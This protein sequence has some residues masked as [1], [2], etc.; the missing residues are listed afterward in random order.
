M[1]SSDIPPPGV[2]DYV[3]PVSSH[4]L[5]VSGTLWTVSYLLYARESLR[6]KSYG[7]PIAALAINFGW[8]V[9]NAFYVAEAPLE[10]AVITAWCLIDLG[11]FYGVVR[12]GP[13]EWE[14]GA[15]GGRTT[16]V[17]RNL[18]AVLG[19]MV[20][21]SLWANWAFA[22]WWIRNEV[23]RREGKFYGGRLAADTTELGYWTASFAQVFLSAAS[24]AQLLVREHSGGVSW[25]I[26][27]TRFSGSLIGLWGA[28]LWLWYHWPEGHPYVTSEI[29]IFFIA[30]SFACDVA[31]APVLWSV[32]RTEKVMPGGSKVSGGYVEPGRRS[33][34][35]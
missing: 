4:M 10:R 27:A 31:Y 24:F 32:R 30:V 16:W 14:R 35:L 33:K 25:S 3:I 6:S 23:G 26:W 7:M 21:L 22:H 34:V 1:G 17:S 13:R 2:P 18:V 29:S 8:E 9:V 12:Y 20:A 11:L 15:G 19:L 28:Y 5:S